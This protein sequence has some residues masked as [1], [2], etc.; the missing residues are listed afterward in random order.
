[1]LR[2]A[3]AEL[4]AVLGSLSDDE[5]GTPTGCA[6]W[7][8]L[9]LACHLVNDVQRA[10][11]ALATPAEEPPVVDAV[12][13]WRPDAPPSGED[14]DDPVAVR[15]VASVQ[16]GIGALA[17]RYAAASSAVVV[18]A[19]RVPPGE[20]VANQGAAM[21]LP[22]LVST[23]VVEAT[24]HHL[25]LVRHL[26]RPGPVAGPLAEVRRVAGALLGAPLPGSW[27]DAT[28]ALRAAGREPLTVADRTSIG[29]LADRFPLL[30]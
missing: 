17:R 19:G 9:D 5:G 10:L 18:A 22:D 29:P 13:Y 4:S 26:D 20:L 7:S 8:A 16:G 30:G 28:A 23:L 25:D 11:V 24:V 21:T 15:V 6:G 14:A 27:D 12:G 3:Y 2:A 1:V